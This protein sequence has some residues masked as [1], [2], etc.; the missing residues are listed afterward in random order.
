[1]NLYITDHS[2]MILMTIVTC[3]VAF[4]LSSKYFHIKQPLRIDINSD[5][6]DN[7]KN[8]R[9][10]RSYNISN[11][12]QNIDT[13]EI[14]EYSAMTSALHKMNDN[15]KI[16][17]IHETIRADVLDRQS[18]KNLRDIDRR[19][20]NELWEIT[21]GPSLYKNYQHRENNRSEI[22]TNNSDS[23]LDHNYFL[24]YA[25]HA[26]SAL[27]QPE[28]GKRYIRH[29][30][31]ISSDDSDLRLISAFF[32]TK[33][34]LLPENQ[35]KRHFFN[36]W[37]GKRYVDWNAEKSVRKSFEKHNA[38]ITN[39]EQC[40][41]LKR[42]FIPQLNP[43]KSVSVAAEVNVLNETKSSM[44]WKNSYAVW[45]DNRYNKSDQLQRKMISLFTNCFM[46]QIRKSC[47][48]E[49]QKIFHCFF[50]TNEISYIVTPTKISRI[51]FLSVNGLPPKLIDGVI[52]SMIY[53]L[54]YVYVGHQIHSNNIL[55]ILIHCNNEKNWKNDDFR[56]KMFCELSSKENLDKSITHMNNERKYDILSWKR[57][58]AP[59]CDVSLNGTV[60]FRPTKQSAIS[61][62]LQNTHILLNQGPIIVCKY[63]K[64]DVTILSEKNNIGRHSEK[65]KNRRGKRELGGKQ[66]L[67][68]RKLPVATSGNEL[69]KDSYL[70]WP[71]NLHLLKRNNSFITKRNERDK[72]SS[73][74]QV[75][76][77]NVY[78]D[79][80][81][82]IIQSLYKYRMK[83]F[84]TYKRVPFSSWGGKRFID[85]DKPS[86][87][88]NVLHKKK[89]EA[90]NE[91]LLN[92]KKT[93]FSAW[94]GKRSFPITT[95]M[96]LSYK[97]IGLSHSP[98]NDKRRINKNDNN[99]SA[100]K[101]AVGYEA[102]IFPQQKHQIQSDKETSMEH[103]NSLSHLILPSQLEYIQSH[104][105]LNPSS[106]K[107]VNHTT[108]TFLSKNFIPFRRRAILSRLG[109]VMVRRRSINDAKTMPVKEPTALRDENFTV[110]SKSDNR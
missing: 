45:L 102:N 67:M 64:A 55:A 85:T 98:K 3:L 100:Q 106:S 25:I 21:P 10:K 58:W 103:A 70:K 52:T 7:N 41:K 43:N 14:A 66:N 29:H 30:F 89:I 13:T 96:Y 92:G 63:P 53:L 33:Q 76:E 91:Y 15:K 37:S 19:L 4:S 8:I 47:S 16:K 17:S 18:R 28:K 99:Q 1:M 82:M 11:N 56:I 51:I 57:N 94:S 34:K 105:A 31:E 20:A 9:E 75:M 88:H 35:S 86:W 48:N 108:P 49:I 107:V 60:A 22:I 6:I 77:E 27:R 95:P 40:I 12:F 109:N 50:S 80:L 90:R 59:T 101:H 62:N 87:N 24:N 104:I 71:R 78:L 26:Q 74:T 36:A 83:S 54:K 79:T 2:S 42:I 73:A 38:T 44:Q 23:S 32:F 93:H 72:F 69:E 65:S 68:L 5:K 81:N 61:L 84:E 97:P 39:V 110:D 46:H